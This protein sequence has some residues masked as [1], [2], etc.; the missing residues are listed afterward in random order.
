MRQLVQVLGVVAYTVGV[1]AGCVGGEAVHGGEDADAGMDGTAGRGGT[2]GT[3]TVL[4]FAGS[5]APDAGADDAAMPTPDAGPQ[6]AGQPDAGPQD[7]G[8]EPAYPADL[9]Q[10]C[11]AD[12]DCPGAGKCMNDW[13]Y[14]LDAPS[15]ARSCFWEPPAGTPCPEGMY[16]AGGT[17]CL[18]PV[19]CADWVATYGSD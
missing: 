17:L 5:D 8:Q 3:V 10:P 11:E 2:G 4:G 14:G 1:F 19:S 9:C 13:L 18:P 7:A 16:L 6:D 15:E 12:L